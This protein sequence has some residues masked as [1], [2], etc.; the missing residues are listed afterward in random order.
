[1]D[2]I[3]LGSLY[4]LFALGIGLIF[5]VMQLIN[6]AHGEL[7][8]ITGYVLVLT[9]GM[10]LPIGLALGL[11][12]AMMIALAMERTAFRPVRG[13]NPATLLVTSF[14]VS[15]ILQSS[16]EMAFGSLPKGVNVS[17]VL[18]EY[19]RV[20]AILIPKLGLLTVGVTFGFLGAFSLF[21]KRTPLGIQMRAAA[22]NFPMAR[23]M[24]V[25]ANHVIAAAFLLSGFLAGLAGFLVVA[26]TGA[27]SPE[28]GANVVV[29]AFVA[30][31]LGGMG[32]L[33]GSVAGGFVLGA[34]TVLLQTYLPLALLPFRDAF[35]FVLVFAMLIIR[36]Q[37]LVVG[38]AMSERV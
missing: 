29:V 11:C 37:G 31:I 26:Q 33:V 2:A 1:M 30:T 3:S 20:G 25:R 6:F 9:S 32:S 34:L 18:T 7:V 12:A 13:A 24:G 10:W 15:V 8:M 21:L 14:A 19:F 16:A 28:M 27:V 22:E 23:L 38:K 5:G 35:V 4:A 17:T 36:P